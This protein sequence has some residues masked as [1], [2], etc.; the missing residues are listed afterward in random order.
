MQDL[1]VH[2][3]VRLH[4]QRRV[5][6]S[7]LCNRVRVVERDEPGECI[8][9]PVE[10]EVVGEA[11]L[12]CVDLGVGRDV[13]GVD[14][15]HV[16]AGLDTVVHEHGVQHCASV[17]R[18]AERYVGHAEGREDAGQ[19]A[20]D[21]ADAL[22]GL[23]GAAAELGI[24]RR[25]RER[26]VIEDQGIGVEAVLVADD[27]VDASCDLELARRRLRHALL[28]DGQRDDGGA[29]LDDVGHHGVN[30]FAAVLQVDGVDGGAAGIALQCGRDDVVLRRVDHER[31]LDALRQQLHDGAHLLALVL[32]LGQRDADVEQV[33]AALDLAA[34]DLEDAV[35]VVGQQHALDGAG[36]L[37]VDALADECRRRHLLQVVRRHG[38]GDAGHAR[39][40]AL[41]RRAAPHAL[42]D[43]AHVV[44]RRAAAAAD[45]AHAEARH[46]LVMRIREFRRRQRVHR[47]A[48]PGS[49]GYRRSG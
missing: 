5:A 39:H 36:S 28:V 40:R 12:F 37:R 44:G 10:D 8:L 23:D 48:A 29:V 33:R 15:G 22:D 26:Q 34:G 11:A 27:V 42:D 30:A 47:L 16:E 1:P 45:D 13:G 2:R 21:E 43:G 25:Q 24:A 41:Q 14:D 35:V 4:L 19:F 18:E 3:L 49:A 20:L 32:P 31:R 46:E 17:L 6:R 9:G 7:F 38:A